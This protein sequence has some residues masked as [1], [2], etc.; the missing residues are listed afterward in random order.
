MKTRLMIQYRLPEES[1]RAGQVTH[2]PGRWGDME[3]TVKGVGHPVTRLLEMWAERGFI[4]N[5]E[6]IIPW[7]GVIQILREEFDDTDAQTN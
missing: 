6:R 2:Y 1:M 5:E 3:I 7:H 4:Q